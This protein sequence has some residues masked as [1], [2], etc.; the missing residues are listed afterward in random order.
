MHMEVEGRNAGEPSS[1]VQIPDLGER[2]QPVRALNR[3]RA[4]PPTVFDRHSESLDERS[5][6]P[7][8][9]LLPR[10]QWISLMGLRQGPLLHTLGSAPSIGWAQI[11]TSAVAT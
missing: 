6:V 4:E 2:N 3:G 11:G 1:R 7:A 5:L 10:N 8:E 9:A